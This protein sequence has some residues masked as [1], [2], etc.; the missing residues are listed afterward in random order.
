MF[1]IASGQ[2]SEDEVASW[3][4]AHMIAAITEDR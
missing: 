1:G 3:I 4:K 2:V